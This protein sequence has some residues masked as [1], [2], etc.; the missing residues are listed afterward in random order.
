MGGERPVIRPPTDRPVINRPVIGNNIQQNNIINTRP[1]WVN[2]NNVTVNN[3]HNQ[4]NTAIVNRPGMHNWINNNPNRYNYWHGWG[5]AVRSNWH[6]F[7]HHHDWFGPNWWLVHRP[8][9]CGWHYR[10]WLPYYPYNY[11][12]SVP[13]WGGI[14]GW[15][16]WNG[17]VWQQ[18]IYYDYGIGGNVYIQNGMVTIGGQAIASPSDFSQSAGALATVA[19]PKSEE[20]AAAVEWMPLGTFALSTGQNDTEPTR[21]VQL[22]VTK[23]GI[24]GGTLYNYQTQQSASIQGQVDKATQRIAFRIGDKDNLVAETGLYNLTQKEAPLLMHFGT[25][26]TES[27]LLIRMENDGEQTR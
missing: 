16:N 25:G 10:Y 5:G 20:A 17:A 12:W 6:Y 24:I 15:L 13:T 2:V 14:L 9:F 21:V 22:A 26:G 27:Y 7:H 11:W 23:D 3:I 18:P 19:P 4:W 8:A 1:A